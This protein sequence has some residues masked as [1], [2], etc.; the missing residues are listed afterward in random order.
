MKLAQLHKDQNQRYQMVERPQSFLLQVYAHRKETKSDLKCKRSWREGFMRIYNLASL[1]YSPPLVDPHS[2]KHSRTSQN[3]T[4][5]C[6]T[7]KFT[8]KQRSAQ[9]LKNFPFSRNPTTAQKINQTSQT[10]RPG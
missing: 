6:H 8:K 1:L 7:R 10:T 9:S 2:P 3:I 4:R 5:N